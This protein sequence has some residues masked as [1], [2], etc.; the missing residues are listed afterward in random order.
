M[1][2]KIRFA[3]IQP[4]VLV[5][6][7]SA[8]LYLRRF[9]ILIFLDDRA[10]FELATYNRVAACRVEPLRHL[11]IFIWCLTQDSNLYLNDFESFFSA[12]WNSKAYG[13]AGRIRTHARFHACRFSRP[14]PSARLGYCTKLFKLIFTIILYYTMLNFSTLIHFFWRRVRDSNSYSFF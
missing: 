5:L 10:R 7:T 12:S 8:T 1:V 11:P 14:I 2:G 13:G 9:P 3:L 6:Q 4:L